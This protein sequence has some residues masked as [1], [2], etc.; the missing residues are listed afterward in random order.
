MSKSP[1]VALPPVDEARRI[2]ANIATIKL[3][4]GDRQH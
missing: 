1:A 2:A 3:R 4:V